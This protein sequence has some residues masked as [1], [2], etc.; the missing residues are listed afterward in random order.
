[1]KIIYSQ[2]HSCIHFDANEEFYFA[3][4][5]VTE[6]VKKKLNQIISN[7]IHRCMWIWSGRAVTFTRAN[8]DERRREEPQNQIYY[9][10]TA[11]QLMLITTII[12]MVIIHHTLTH[13]HMCIQ[14]VYRPISAYWRSMPTINVISLDF[15]Q[16]ASR[17]LK[18]SES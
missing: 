2:P 4:K 18:W 13:T 11:Q 1:M 7:K 16:L 14:H 6:R 3:Y 15:N 10:L 9:E 12:V 17:I 8:D 5:C